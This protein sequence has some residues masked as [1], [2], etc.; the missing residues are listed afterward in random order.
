MI[1]TLMVSLVLTVFSLV[2][3]MALADPVSFK[4][5]GYGC[6]LKIMGKA[7]GRID[8]GSPKIVDL[9]RGREYLVECESHDIPVKLYARANL[10]AKGDFRTA[11]LPSEM[12]LVPVA[13]LPNLARAAAAKAINVTAVADTMSV[14]CKVTKDPKSPGETISR[15]TVSPKPLRIAKGT[16]AQLTAT[17][18][19]HCG[20]TNLVEATVGGSKGW[21]RNRDFAFAY[22]GKPIE[23]FSPSRDYACCW[24]E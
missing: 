24:I 14:G 1:R 16:S 17:P 2:P 18:W 5:E 7:H 3:R 10:F 6:D 21:F 23:L 4:A 13:V 15:Q 22:K 9:P 12:V 19:M 11:P 20:D 8:P